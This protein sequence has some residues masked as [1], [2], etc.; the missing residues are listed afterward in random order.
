MSN[1]TQDKHEAEEFYELAKDEEPPLYEGCTKYSRLSFL[2][3]LHHIKCGMSHKA[4]TMI[5]ELLNDA[6]GH[7]KIPS[8]F[9]E[10]KKIIPHTFEFDS[11]TVVRNRDEVVCFT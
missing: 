1:A 3:K 6:F 5:L 7:A 11:K 8:S 2:V 9:C 4:M 10:A